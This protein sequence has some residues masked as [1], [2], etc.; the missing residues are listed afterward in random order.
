MRKYVDET[1]LINKQDVIKK[2]NT[3]SN[4]ILLEDNSEYRLTDVDSLTFS[5]PNTEFETWIKLSLKSTGT[6]SISFPSSTKYIGEPP[7]FSNSQTWEISIK[8][9]VVAAWRVS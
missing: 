6:I 7:I 3:Y 4:S 2:F 1:E 5:Y 8:D 9:G